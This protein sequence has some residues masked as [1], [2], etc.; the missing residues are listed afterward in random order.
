LVLLSPCFNVADLAPPYPAFA[1]QH[2]EVGNGELGGEFRADHMKIWP[3]QG[4]LA[5][6]RAL[7]EVSAFSLAC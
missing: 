2:F 6:L 3:A 1:R 5:R 4:C 7:M